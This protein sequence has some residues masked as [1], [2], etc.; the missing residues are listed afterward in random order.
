ARPVWRR[1]GPLGA[2]GPGDT[3]SRRR[4]FVCRPRSASETDELSC[5]RRIVQTLSPRAF[6]RPVRD[7]G[8]DKLMDFYRQGRR[9]GDFETGVER[10]LAGIL[11]APAFV[12]RIEEEP[13]N[14][15]DGGVYRASDLALASRLSFF[16]SSSRSGE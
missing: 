8:V 13:A 14:V 4:I 15:P 11:V 6:R 12:L 3:P 7:S 16:I 1:S 2:D 10:A 5:A 9:D